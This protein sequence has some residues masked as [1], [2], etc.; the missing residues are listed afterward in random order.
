MSLSLDLGSKPEGTEVKAS[1]YVGGVRFWSPEKTNH[2]TLSLE[3]FAATVVYVLGNTDLTPN[4]PRVEL[5]ERLRRIR[6]IEGYNGPG[7]K[8]LEVMGRRGENPEG[9]LPGSAA[10]YV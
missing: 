9:D 5:M 3:D 4:D 7:S 8:R 6:V 2:I 10:S 1:P